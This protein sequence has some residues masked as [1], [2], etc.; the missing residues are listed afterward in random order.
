MSEDP[1]TLP[2]I[3]GVAGHRD[4]RADD[5]EA[6][7]A[8]IKGI[9]AQLAAESPSTPLI[10]V[11]ALANVARAWWFENE[12]QVTVPHL[13]GRGGEIGERLVDRIAARCRAAN[14]RLLILLQG[15]TPRDDALAVLAHARERG[16]ATLDLATEFR[17]L[18]AKDPGL[19][20]R[21]FRGH[22]TR[23]GNGWVAERVAA[24]LR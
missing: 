15:D 8:S 23:E 14:V 4:L 19:H 18:H 16:V 24:A 3:V 5:G 6:L 1:G 22:M 11:S 20:E 10:V 17:A 13:K 12:K 2:L 9:F 7:R 21:W